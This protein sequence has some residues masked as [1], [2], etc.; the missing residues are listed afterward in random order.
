LLGKH[1]ALSSN[2]STG[3]TKKDRKRERKGGRDGRE[4]GRKERREE[5]REEERKKGR[6]GGRK[7]TCCYIFLPYVAY[8]PESVFLLFPTLLTCFKSSLLSRL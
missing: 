8:K 3:K 2:P 4:G 6:E 7:E 1:E 5:G